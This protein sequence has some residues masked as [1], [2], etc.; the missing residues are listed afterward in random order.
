MINTSKSRASRLTEVS[1]YKKC[2]AIGPR[3]QLLPGG[4]AAKS[5]RASQLCSLNSSSVCLIPFQL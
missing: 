1:N 2:I 5:H 4:D 3:K